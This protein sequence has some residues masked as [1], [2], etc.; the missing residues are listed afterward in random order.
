LPSDKPLR[1]APWGF[2]KNRTSG[3]FTERFEL[4]R[5]TSTDKTA[6]QS[7]FSP[8]SDGFFPTESRYFSVFLFYF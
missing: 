5:H 4:L 6:L 2:P 3:F 1:S 8:R 7:R